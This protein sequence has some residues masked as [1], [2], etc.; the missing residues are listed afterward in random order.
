MKSMSK[1]WS[2]QQVRI[3]NWFK[4]GRGH[5]IVR[6]RAGTGKTTTILEAVTHAPENKILLAAFNKRIARELE[7][8]LGG[9]KF[10]APVE[11]KTLHGLGYSFVKYAWGKDIQPDDAVEADRVRVVLNGLAGV[12]QIPEE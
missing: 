8:K 5:L 9:W 3:F 10:G 6:A 1:N 12:S 4:S 7:E 11:A 2:E